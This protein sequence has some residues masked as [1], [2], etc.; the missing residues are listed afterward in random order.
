MNKLLS[1][2]CF[3]CGLVSIATSISAWYSINHET[4]I[5]IGIWV[6]TLLILS[7]KFEPK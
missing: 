4:G 1:D 7:L 3:V 5:F 6:P 2:I